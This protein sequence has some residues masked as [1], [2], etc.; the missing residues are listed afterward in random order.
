MSNAASK[1]A[2]LVLLCLAGCAAPR[3]DIRDSPDYAEIEAPR[4]SYADGSI[5]QASS[6]G[7]AE[8]MKARKKGD[9]LTVVIAEQASASNEATTGTSRSA[10]VSAGIPNLLG[11]ET[12]MTG[13]KNW[14]DLSRLINASTDSTYDGTGSTT[15]R[16]DLNATITARVIDVLPN[17]N[18]LIEGRRNVRVNNEEQII[19][20]QG[21]VRPRDITFDNVVYSTSIADARIT[22][23]GKGIISDRQ[24]PG[25]L[26]N[27][28]DAVWPF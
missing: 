28:L 13:I 3:S 26:M 24:R 23:T 19:L 1:I 16:E 15:R 4:R 10:S 12:K 17:G 11:L 9:S 21:M 14:M 22:Y 5:W 8:D 2:F 6:G 20:L 7:I 18:F 27:I 25:W